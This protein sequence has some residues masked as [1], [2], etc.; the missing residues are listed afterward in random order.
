[1]GN[2]F[3]KNNGVRLTFV[4]ENRKLSVF[5][6]FADMQKMDILG[7]T[8]AH[9]GNLTWLINPKRYNKIMSRELKNINKNSR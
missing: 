1:M 8:I 6:D 3:L 9:F 4:T 2:H 7:K 5:G